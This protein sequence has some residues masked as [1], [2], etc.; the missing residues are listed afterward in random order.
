MSNALF[1]HDKLNAHCCKLKKN[2]TN[3]T[4]S[5]ADAEQNEFSPSQQLLI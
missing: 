4:P 1:P 5:Q 2:P 3:Q